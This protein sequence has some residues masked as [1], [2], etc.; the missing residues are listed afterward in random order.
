[1]ASGSLENIGQA[2]VGLRTNMRL[3]PKYRRLPHRSLKHELANMFRIEAV[4]LK[5]GEDG[6][7]YNQNSIYKMV[8]SATIETKSSKIDNKLLGAVVKSLCAGLT[9]DQSQLIELAEERITRAY[10]GSFFKDQILLVHH[11][12]SHDSKLVS[13]LIFTYRAVHG[14]V[15]FT[16]PFPAGRNVLDRDAEKLGSLKGYITRTRNET[17]FTGIHDKVGDVEPRTRFY[18]CP[19]HPNPSSITFGTIHTTD[20]SKPSTLVDVCFVVE[21]LTAETLNMAKR[22]ITDAAA[23]QSLECLLTNKQ[24]VLELYRNGISEPEKGSEVWDAITCLTKHREFEE[25]NFLHNLAEMRAIIRQSLSNV[26]KSLER[27]L[28]NLGELLPDAHTLDVQRRV[29]EIEQIIHR[30]KL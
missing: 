30:L 17:I 13:G 12:S 11:N 25:C 14:P 7:P 10:T 4:N 24:A 29:D 19:T 20:K 16:A 3:D 26:P 2:I 27:Q 22:N 6:K 21:R 18:F 15:E 23:I 1:M 5:T 9:E 28:P 8:D